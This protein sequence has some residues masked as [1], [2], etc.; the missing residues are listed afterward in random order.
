MDYPHPIIAKEGWTHLTVAVVLA[1][2][3]TIM[4][5]WWSLPFWIAALFVLQFFRDPPRAVPAGEG[6]VLSHADGCIVVV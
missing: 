4:A 2:A 1:G 3:V 6:I 5:G